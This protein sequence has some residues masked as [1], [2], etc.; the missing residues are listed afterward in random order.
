MDGQIKQALAA[1]SPRLRAAIT[2]TAIQGMSIEDAA[3]VEGCLKATLYWRIH[4]AWRILKD[5]LKV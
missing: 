1:L 2:L 5:T 3:K 4:E